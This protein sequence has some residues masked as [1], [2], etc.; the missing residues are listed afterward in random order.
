MRFGYLN[1]SRLIGINLLFVNR[2]KDSEFNKNNNVTEFKGTL[3]ECY[4]VLHFSN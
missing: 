3:L 4:Q 2:G 1:D